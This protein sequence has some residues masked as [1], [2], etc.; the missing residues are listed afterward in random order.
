MQ[1]FVKIFDGRLVKVFDTKIDKKKRIVIT[2][3]N[4]FQEEAEVEFF[5]NNKKVKTLLF[6]NLPPAKA[7][8]LNIPVTIELI[9]LDTL[10]FSYKAANK[11]ENTIEFDI[12]DI[13]EKNYTKP[14]IATILVIFL[15]LFLI[16]VGFFVFNNFLTNNL[17]N[18]YSEITTTTLIKIEKTTDTTIS[19]DE[20][21]TDITSQLESSTNMGDLSND[22]IDNS[23]LESLKEFIQ[24]NTPL[25]FI[26]DKAV[27]K[28]NENKKLDK[29][30][31]YLKNYS[32]VSLLIKGHTANIN[33]P[34]R[35]KKLSIERAKK[36]AKYIKDNANIST[37]IDIKGMGSTEKSIFNPSKDQ[38]WLNRRVEIIVNSGKK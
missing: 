32:S 34:E 7:R 12:S 33:K 19:E 29:I 35:E 25:Y 17:K 6:T 15:T 10:I 18:N 28:K 16:G 8:V 3:I 30:I 11:K 36:I 20:T 2:T 13:R 31:N 4:D 38:K 26:K 1:L 24:L 27:L 37:N 9:D 5:V 14:I 22:Y 21:T 23:N